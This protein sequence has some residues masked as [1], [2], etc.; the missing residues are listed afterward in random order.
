VAFLTLRGLGARNAARFMFWYHGTVDGQEDEGTLPTGGS[1]FMFNSCLE[2]EHPH[3]SR[4]NTKA[5][6]GSSL[7]SQPDKVVSQYMHVA[8]SS[9][10]WHILRREDE[11]GFGHLVSRV[12]E[13]R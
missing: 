6:R 5:H 10:P 7:T 4:N 1:P 8:V 9:P 13:A 2:H 11:P 3:L 12:Q